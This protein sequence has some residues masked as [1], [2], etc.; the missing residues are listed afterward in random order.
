MFR[1]SARFSLTTCSG[2]PVTGLGSREIDLLGLRSVGRG[3]AGG[4]ERRELV[5]DSV[6]DSAVRYNCSR[7]FW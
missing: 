7:L 2:S 1:C 6:S 5:P 3:P 4:E